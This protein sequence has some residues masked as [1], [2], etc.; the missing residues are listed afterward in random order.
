MSLGLG[1]LSNK[2]VVVINE[3][4]WHIAI[5]ACFA[6]FYLRAH[7][8]ERRVKILEKH[9]IAM[10]KQILDLHIQ[11]HGAGAIFDERK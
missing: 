11:V 1:L 5:F 4:W 2:E 9:T 3:S 6:S 7:M 8:S 10:Q